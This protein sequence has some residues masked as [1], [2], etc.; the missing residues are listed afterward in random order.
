MSS[1]WRWIAL[2]SAKFAPAGRSKTDGAGL[3]IADIG[4]GSGCI[5]VT[6]AKELPAAQFV[7]TD[8]SPA[9]LEVARRNAARHGVA[10]RI[11]FLESNLLER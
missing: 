11:H 2:P 5:V 4:T 1:K 3:R 6:L 9:A 8:I 7:A 10:D